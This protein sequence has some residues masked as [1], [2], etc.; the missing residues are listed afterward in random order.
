[1]SGPLSFAGITVI[2]V[3]L[4][5]P[6]LGGPQ[7]PSSV[8]A[9]TAAVTG[10]GLPVRSNDQTIGNGLASRELK[11]S[12]D[13]HF[14]A[15]AQ[16][17]GA[18]IRFLVDTGASFVALT[19]NDARRAGIS[20]RSERVKALGAGG[21]LEVTP[22]TI[23]RIALGP[24]V[25]SDIGGAII[26]DLPISLLGQSYLSQVGSVTIEGDRMVLR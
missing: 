20:A 19:P 3:L 1:M 26:D 24:L 11:R 5:A 8:P 16:V 6:D 21:E 10:T 15:D 22:V 7:D 9:Q 14:Y 23:D 13:G 25:A 12:L 2:T 4:L 18:R 17:N